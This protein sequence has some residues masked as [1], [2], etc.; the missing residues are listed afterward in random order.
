MPKDML[1]NSKDDIKDIYNNRANATKENSE[2][3]FNAVKKV[4]IKTETM[5]CKYCGKKL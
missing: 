4:L 1:I 2:I 3:Y 5:F